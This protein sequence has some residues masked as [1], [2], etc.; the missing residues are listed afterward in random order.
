M[1][2]RTHT[3]TIPA[4]L[5]AALFFMAVLPGGAWARSEKLVYIQDF[6]IEEGFPANDPVGR[7]IKNLLVEVF[8]AKTSYEI[9]EDQTVEAALEEEQ[10]A[11]GINKCSDE[12]CIRALMERIDSELMVYGRV[13]KAE[14][15]YH[16]TAKMLDRSSGVAR[17]SRI[18]TLKFKYDDMFERAIRALG[19]YLVT[20]DNDAIDQFLEKVHDRE[21]NEALIL[22]SSELENKMQ[23]KRLEAEKKV[24]EAAAEWRRSMLARSPQLRVG[25]GAVVTTREPD[26]DKYYTDRSAYFVDWIIRMNSSIEAVPKYD[27]YYRLFYKSMRMSDSAVQG[28]TMFEDPVTRGKADIYGIDWGL[29]I[30]WSGYFMMTSF[31][32]YVLGAVRGQYYREQAPDP[33]NNKET[34]KVEFYSFGGYGGAGIEIAF[35][36]NL[37]FFVEFNTGYTPVGDSKANLEGNQLYCGVTLRSDYTTM[38]GCM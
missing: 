35:F 34:L 11:Q 26:F 29:R 9:T 24:R 14:G 15:S 25:Y 18:R 36:R 7:D 13:K 21:E 22:K 31:D 20:G 6:A 8:Q 27:M 2:T 23:E 33:L 19:L 17:L 12:N 3:L 10:R 30:R 37:G 1:A 32:F 38:A 4:L 16:I 28:G 5:F